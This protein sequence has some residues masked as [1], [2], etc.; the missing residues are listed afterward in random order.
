[1]VQRSEQVTGDSTVLPLGG[2]WGA[3]GACCAGW[4]SAVPKMLLGLE[5]LHCLELCLQYPASPRS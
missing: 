2:L 5:K 4:V 3:H 1:M